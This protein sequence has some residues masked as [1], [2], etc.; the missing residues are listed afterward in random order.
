M[1]K[2]S[3]QGKGYAGE[4]LSLLKDYAYNH[5]HLN[6][7]IALCSVNNTGSSGL[8]EK[9][10]FIREGCLQQNTLISNQYVDDYIYG[11]CKSDL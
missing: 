9:L 1:I 5:L 8:L 2:Q 6:K 10:G 11:L 4:A 3:A 7:L